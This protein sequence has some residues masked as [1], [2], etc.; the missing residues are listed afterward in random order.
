MSNSPS[1]QPDSPSLCTASSLPIKG[2]P[3]P[4][5]LLT[6]SRKPGKLPAAGDGTLGKEG[7]PVPAGS[8]GRVEEHGIGPVLTGNLLPRLSGSWMSSPQP[9]PCAASMT[10]E[11]AALGSRAFACLLVTL[12]QLGEGLASLT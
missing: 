6:A 12:E 9:P 8:P 7:G 11:S 10:C 4:P 1:P 2:V 3:F 5:L